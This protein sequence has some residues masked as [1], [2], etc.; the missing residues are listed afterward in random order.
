[1]KLID[2]STVLIT[3]IFFKKSNMIFQVRSCLRVFVWVHVGRMGLKI[4][5][6]TEGEAWQKRFGNH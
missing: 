3:V 6:F 1:M 4:F 5:F 2:C